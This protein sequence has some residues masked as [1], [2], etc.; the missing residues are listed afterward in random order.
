MKEFALEKYQRIKRQAEFKKIIKKGKSYADKYLVM[1]VL[2]KSSEVNSA[3]SSSRKV[4][5][6]AESRLPRLG[7][8]LD[9]R[10][11][12]A[13]IRNRIKRWMREVFRLRQSRLKDRT[14]IILIAR[15]SAKELV[16]YFEMEKRILN[17]WRRARI[18]RN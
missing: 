14:E 4:P 6:V 15:S 12:K 9:R 10:I 16:D 2:E 13:V 1:Y 18:V 5:Q 8:S 17:L 3:I 7:L 11:G